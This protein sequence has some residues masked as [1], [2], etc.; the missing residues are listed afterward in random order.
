MKREAK[1][2]LDKAVDSLI[3]S[4]ELFNRPHE[5]CRHTGSLILLDHSFEMLLKAAIIHNGGRIRDRRNDKNTIGFDVCLRKAVSDARIKFLTEEQVLTLQAINGER[6]AA[7]HHI[8]KMSEQQ[9][10]VHMQSGFTLFADIMQSVFDDN[11]KTRLPERVL[12]VATLAPLDI[13]K[14]FRFEVKEI[15][16]LLAPRSRKAIEA[17]SRI[18]PLAILNSTILG[19]RNTQPSDKDIKKIAEKIRDGV[20]WR[21]IFKGVAAIKIDEEGTG[22]SIALR[23]VKKGG[24]EVTLVKEGNGTGNVVAVKTVREL[25]YYSLGLKQLTNN[26]SKTFP[27][28]STKLLA[29]IK[30]LG[31]FENEKYFKEFKISS[32]I[33]KRYSAGA[34]KYLLQQLPQL[35]VENN[36]RNWR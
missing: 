10:Y 15:K 14:L 2:L 9:L 31:M 8:L 28:T 26:I 27:I 22:P 1:I 11:I 18:R 20:D 35:D 17:D 23:I 30:H 33:H 19:E 32:Q 6:D 4:I 25:D 21:T 34:Q 3:L 13:E 36:W 7:Q 24:V 5:Q 12:P 29:V 16:K